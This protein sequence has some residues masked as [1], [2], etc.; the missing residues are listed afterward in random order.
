MFVRN[1]LLAGLSVVT[2][3]SGTSIAHLTLNHTSMIGHETSTDSPIRAWF[4]FDDL[5][6]MQSTI[7][8]NI[9]YP[10]N[11]WQSQSINSTL[12]APE[13]KGRVDATRTFDGAELNTEY[14]FGL[15]AY[16]ALNPNATTLLGVPMSYEIIHFTA[17]QNIASAAVIIDFH[18]TMI[19]MTLPIEVDIWTMWDER[20]QVVQ[21]DVTFRWFQYLL[22]TILTAVKER[23]HLPTEQGATAYL[24]EHIAMAICTT[25]DRHCKGTDAQYSGYDSCM[26]FLTEQRFGKAYELGADTLLCRMLHQSMVPARP[27]VHCPHIGPSGGGMCVDDY[28]YRSKVLEPYFTL[29]AFVPYGYGSR[30]G[31]IAAM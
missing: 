18:I 30:S 31:D 7:L 27:Q 22:D 10:K 28:S 29:G 5:W 11:I 1:L 9:L 4:H 17:N 15:W 25:H 13:V 3:C 20:G 16:I 21:Y 2:S 24:Q 6:N 8:D 19:N 23:F 12:L 26:A 14:L